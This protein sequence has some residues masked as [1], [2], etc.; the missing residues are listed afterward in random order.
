MGSAATPACPFCTRLAAF[1]AGTD[2]DFIA[3]L[4]HSHL[5]LGE[6]MAWPGWCILVL[7]EHAEHLDQLEPARRA[8]IMGEAARV[9]AALRAAGLA[10]RVNYECLGNV[11]NHIH[12]H[13]IP[14]RAD[15][16]EPTK[17]VWN[18]PESERQRSGTPE[19]RADVIRRVRAAL[20]RTR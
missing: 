4:E 11:V 10:S 3:A 16:P 9:G 20:A 6:S 1:A 17:T 18:R 7:K 14:R 12:W 19:D 13:V 5:I 8:A 15:E 2:Q